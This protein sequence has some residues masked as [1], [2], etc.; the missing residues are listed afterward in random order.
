MPLD[1]E[2]VV[3]GMRQYQQLLRDLQRE[4]NLAL[5]VLGGRGLDP[6]Q[7][8]LAGVMGLVRVPQGEGKPRHGQQAIGVGAVAPDLDV[9]REK[10][11]GDGHRVV[12]HGLE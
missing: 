8:R 1:P 5:G 7:D 2:Q 3:E 6:D 10:P 12:L 9:G 11:L 4:H